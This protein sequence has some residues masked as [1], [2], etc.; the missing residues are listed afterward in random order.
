MI[1]DKLE[2]TNYREVNLY[3]K[4][5]SQPNGLFLIFKELL[6]HLDNSRSAL[7]LGCYTGL[8]LDYLLPIC[9]P[10]NKNI[11]M[12]ESFASLDE[13][14]RDILTKE[15]EQKYS[16]PLIKWT[17]KDASLSDNLLTADFTHISTGI[18]FPIEQY[19][20]QVKHRA[21]W[22]VKESPWMYE[23]FSEL[24]YTKQIYVLF[25][26]Q[27]I[28]IISNDPSLRDLLD[29]A[30]DKLNNKLNTIKQHLMMKNGIFTI[31]PVSYINFNDHLTDAVTQYDSDIA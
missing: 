30:K 24:F 17:W 9:S 15:I 28:I 1:L 27:D 4:D 22:Y 16:H 8:D 10:L 23:K 31:R 14:H 3:F 18:D 7:D 11:E 25:Y 19:I 21:T 2:K 29:K 5:T 12:V 26:S 6:S 13:K 20:K